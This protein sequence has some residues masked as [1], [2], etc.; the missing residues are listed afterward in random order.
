MNNDEMSA[1][2]QDLIDRIPSDYC[3]ES[4]MVTRDDIETLKAARQLLIVRANIIDDNEKMIEKLGE[5]IDALKKTLIEEQSASMQSALESVKRELVYDMIGRGK[6]A[7]SAAHRAGIDEYT[8]Y[9]IADN[10][11]EEFNYQLGPH[12][13]IP[14]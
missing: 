5:Q 4:M 7:L 6:F 9:I 1:R 10:V 11:L 8:M 13:E 2:L 3:V 12:G 14:F